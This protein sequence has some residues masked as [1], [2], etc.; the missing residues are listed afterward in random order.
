MTLLKKLDATLICLQKHHKEKHHNL[1][2]IATILQTE[3]PDIDFGE[4]KS[5]LNKLKKDG[6]ID[7]QEIPIPTTDSTEIYYNIN[8]EGR[9]FNEQG[10]YDRRNEQNNELTVLRK[11]QH[12]LQVQNRNLTIA[13]AIGTTVA[14]LYYGLEIF[15]YF[16]TQFHK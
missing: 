3:Q 10:G 9:I 1:I 5:I 7:T 13:V 8:F 6:F 14:A 4:I 16:F 11:Q 12:S 2:S 15:K